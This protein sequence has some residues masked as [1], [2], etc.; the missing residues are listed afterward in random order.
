[1]YF[2]ICYP[3]MF[4]GSIFE[5]CLLVMQGTVILITSVLPHVM[6]QVLRFVRKSLR[7]YWNLSM[8]CLPL[9][10]S[11]NCTWVSPC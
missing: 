5:L 4:L 10:C 3:L 11:V 1:M 7:K 2:F 6:H 9:G 8:S